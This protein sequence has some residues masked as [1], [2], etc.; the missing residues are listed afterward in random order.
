MSTGPSSD[1]ANITLRIGEAVTRIDATARRV[2]IGE[3][4]IAFDE[5][6]LTT[7]SAPI[8]L[9]AAI[10]GYLGGVFCVRT[11]ADIDAMGPYFTR[12]GRIL[13]VGGG[14]IGLEAAAVAAKLGL[15]VTV[16]EIAGRILQRVAAP[17]TADYFRALHHSQGVTIR[18]GVGLAQ[19]SGDGHVTSAVLS[20]ADVLD[21]D[22]VIV[23]I[24]IRPNTALADNAGFTI[25]NGIR[26]DA[27][28][29][30]SAPHI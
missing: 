12:G 21:V 2:S 18:E 11:F 28:G 22:F 3:E 25:E 6:V 5:L 13:I 27:F 23:G 10:G 14:Y 29:A 4:E 15:H 17:Q 30:T 26:T 16:V 7:G 1:D 8:R 24:G 20:D 9:P 19:L